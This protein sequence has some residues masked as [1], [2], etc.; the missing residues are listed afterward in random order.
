ML[1]KTDPL[2]ATLCRLEPRWAIQ[3]RLAV[4]DTQTMIE[5]SKSERLD[6][7]IRRLADMGVRVESTNRS[8]QR[9]EVQIGF[10]ERIDS[11][12]IEIGFLLGQW[13][14][15]MGVEYPRD[16]PLRKMCACSH[17]AYRMDVDPGGMYFRFDPL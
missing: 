5:M 1:F 6:A 8:R 9:T 13:S 10:E 3:P 12:W 17:S 16:F 7:L 11:E 14:S 15:M 2:F 4:L